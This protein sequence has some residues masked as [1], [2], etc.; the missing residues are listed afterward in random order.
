MQIFCK[1]ETLEIITYTYDV[2]ETPG[3]YSTDGFACIQCECG[4]SFRPVSVESL[5]EPET[6]VIRGISG[7]I[8][9]NAT[10]NFEPV[11]EEIIP[12]IM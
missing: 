9:L 10:V 5:G 2:W 6:I 12:E 7:Y 3:E 11:P 4:N 1:I 8:Y